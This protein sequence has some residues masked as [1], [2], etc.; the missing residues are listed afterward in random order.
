MPAYHQVPSRVRVNRG[1]RLAIEQARFCRYSL[2][3]APREAQNAEKSPGNAQAAMGVPEHRES[4]RFAEW[5]LR[6]YIRNTQDDTIG[7]VMQKATG[8]NM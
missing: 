8:S 7:E 1:A 5:A 6:K 3:H 4:V 2:Y